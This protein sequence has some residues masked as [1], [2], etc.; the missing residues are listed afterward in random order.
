MR[1]RAVLWFFFCLCLSQLGHA[2]PDLGNKV[3][4][5]TPRRAVEAA[6]RAA[7]AGQTAALVDAMDLRDIPIAKRTDEGAVLAADLARTLT[8]VGVEPKNLSDDPEGDPLDGIGV[9][10]V[11]YA[12]VGGDIIVLS[13]AKA[14]GQWLFSRATVAMLPTLREA[15]IGPGWTRHVPASLREPF[16]LGLAGY[17]WI[18]ILA[19]LALGGLFSLVA[20]RLFRRVSEWIVGGTGQRFVR[21]VAGLGLALGSIAAKALLY[22]LDLRGT[23]EIACDRFTTTTLIL[24]L[25][26]FFMRLVHDGAEIMAARLPEDTAG[27]LHARSVRTQLFVT[28]RVA[29]VLIGF[30]AAAL[31][32]VQ[33]QIVR[34]IGMSLLASAGLAGIVLGLAAQK[35]LAAI[36]AGI[37]ISITQPIRIGDLVVMETE[38]GIVEEI[39]LTFVVLKLLDDRRLVVPIARVLEQPFQNWTRQATKLTVSFP[40]V[41]GPRLPVQ[42]VRDELHR[43]AE[44]NALWD[45][46][47]ASLVV[48]DLT[49]KGLLLRVNLSVSRPEHGFVLRNEVREG[50]VTYLQGVDGGKHLVT[51]TAA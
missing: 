29:T 27:E 26:A 18:G 17:Q 40:L 39:T 16:A 21:P 11:A 9:D 36:V 38:T 48:G 4:R 42:P 5:S 50:L 3:D 20:A 44:A 1:G 24:G 32:L 12:P 47:E 22:P 23:A 35:S 2:G 10:I 14:N 6:L 49:E 33:F 43:L 30:V 8:K 7:T 15:S 41:V 25:A 13:V 19:A 51:P 31:V 28:R 37:Q 45:K 34:T 46:R